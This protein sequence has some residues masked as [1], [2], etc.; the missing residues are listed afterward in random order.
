MFLPNP[1]LEGV[2]AE[3]LEILKA[4]EETEEQDDS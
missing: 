1:E 3:F 4:K 2:P